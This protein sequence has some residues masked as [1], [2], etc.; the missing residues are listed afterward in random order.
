MQKY[1]V[2]QKGYDR[3]SSSET[4]NNTL[5]G[6]KVCLQGIGIGFFAM[7]ITS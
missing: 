6:L 1:V 5:E 2:V 4:C 3:I 7:K